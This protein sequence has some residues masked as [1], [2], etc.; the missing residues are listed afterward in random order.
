MKESNIKPY[1]T[2]Y[3]KLTEMSLSELAKFLAA[4]VDHTRAPRE[5]NEIFENA[6]DPTTGK[7]IT[8]ARA[9]EIW[10]EQ[11]VNR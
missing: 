11:E 6:I 8:W 7:G 10:L 5:V 9:F 2:N 1:I 3:A 4:H